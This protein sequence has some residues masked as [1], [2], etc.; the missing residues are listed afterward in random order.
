MAKT[1]TYEKELSFQGR[2]INYL[3]KIREQKNIVLRLQNDE[4]VV[5]APF[6]ANEWEIE[7]I[8]YKNIR[9]IEAYLKFI[10][11]YKVYEL[12]GT[13]KYIKIWGQNFPFAY[14][15]DILTA[16]EKS[17]FKFF[18]RQYETTN[19]TVLKM[20]NKLKKVYENEFTERIAYWA[21]LMDLEFKNLTVR[22]FKGKWGVCYPS[23]SKILLNIRLIHYDKRALDYVCVHELAHL[24]HGNHSRDFWHFV[25]K[26]LPD[27][28]KRAEI[29]KIKLK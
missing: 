1:L 4:I 14:E 22:W 29:L 28:K 27:Y 5:S 2:K 6:Y 19:K 12:N 17:E 3:L 15:S 26:Y 10:D 8:I 21:N 24:R 23:K 25:E 13:E 7:Q 18:F 16:D 11:T 9:K 20:Y